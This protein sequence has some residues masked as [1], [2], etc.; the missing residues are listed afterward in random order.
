MTNSRDYKTAKIGTYIGFAIKAGKVVFGTDNIYSTTPYIVVA[1]TTLS[2]NAQKKLEARC[3]LLKIPLIKIQGLGSLIS[4]PSCKAVG[5]KEKNLA[6]AIISVTDTEPK[7]N[8][9]NNE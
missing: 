2:A 1:D 4:K 5:I 8:S 7:E 9:N 3:N 6:K